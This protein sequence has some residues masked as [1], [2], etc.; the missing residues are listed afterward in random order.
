M[1]KAQQ[2]FNEKTGLPLGSGL[3]WNGRLLTAK[4]YIGGKPKYIA[5]KTD[6]WKEALKVRDRE[7][8]ALLRSERPSSTL[9]EKT[10]I[11]ELFDDYLSHLRLLNASRGDY[12]PKTAYIVGLTYNKHL[13]NFFGGIRAAKLDTT[14]LTKYRHKRVSEGA[15]G[16]T[17][18][19]E[20][21]YLRTALN[22]GAKHTPAKVIKANI[23]HFAI[24]K[25][26]A[27]TGA[28]T[29]TFTQE[30][31]DLL[32]EHLPEY[33]KPLF[34]FCMYTAARK[35]EA[36][37]VRREKVDWEN[38]RVTLRAGETKSGL[39]RT[40]GL[41][42]SAYDVIW[43][44]EQQTRKHYPHCRFLFHL[45]GKQIKSFDDAFDGA[46]VRAGLAVVRKD[47]DG[48]T[49]LDKD[50]KPLM[51]KLVHWHD[52]RRTGVTLMGSI[53]GINDTDRGRVAGQTAPTLARYDQGNSADKIRDAIDAKENRSNGRTGKLSNSLLADQL[54]EIAELHKQGVLDAEEFRAAKQ[55]LL[56]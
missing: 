52:S 48:K 32:M 2:R 35:K 28:K 38:R 41:P 34:A 56:V 7:K 55:K 9:V 12:S 40:V 26:N 45:D 27:R 42:K 50:G 6:N 15:T 30:Q 43:E 54:K 49:I 23:P 25:A 20:L 8:A 18:D 11:N 39:E 19:H 22:I 51:D 47:E 3:F 46:C 53:E 31:H 10:T 16:Y 44:W 1:A 17:I 24:D 14:L 13:K 4:V 5:T 36:R 37:F 33:L 29:G 21:G